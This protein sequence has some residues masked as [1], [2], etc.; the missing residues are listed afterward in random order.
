MASDTLRDGSKS[1]KTVPALIQQITSEIISKIPKQDN[2]ND[3]NALPEESKAVKV[4]SQKT[5]SKFSKPRS[6]QDGMSIE[7]K[8]V[9]AV[10]PTDL[11]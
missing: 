4:N 10:L 1:N 11:T 3:A 9:A 5:E 8:R 6:E 2:Y 7:N